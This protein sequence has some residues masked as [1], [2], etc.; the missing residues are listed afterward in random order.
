MVPLLRGTEGTVRNI[1]PIPM[2]QMLYAHNMDVP[3]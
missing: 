2:T 3:D 1:I